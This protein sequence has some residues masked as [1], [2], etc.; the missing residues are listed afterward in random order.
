MIIRHI[1]HLNG[2]RNRVI[3]RAK[4]A[5]AELNHHGYDKMEALFSLRYEQ[6]GFRPLR[7]GR[8]TIAEQMNQSF[9]TLAV[10]AG[11]EIIFREIQGCRA[12][13]LSPGIEGGFD[14]ES[15]E[16][17]L[18]AAQA[19]S[20]IRPSDNTKLRNDART[21]SRAVARHRYVFFYSL[22]EAPALVAKVRRDFPEVNVR[23]LTWAELVG[24]ANF[25]MQIGL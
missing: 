10:F 6:I 4:V 19:F 21:V 20:A 22:D 18:V 14:I 8:L 24:Q 17:G 1:E 2:P 25:G 3:T 5:Y 11:V 13:R 23:P 7:D 16:E 9:H 12:V 15:E